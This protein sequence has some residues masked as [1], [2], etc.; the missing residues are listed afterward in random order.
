MFT[1]TRKTLVRL[2]TALILTTT[3]LHSIAQDV[4]T[5]KVSQLSDQQVIQIWQQFAA[6]GVSESDAMKALVKR[7]LKPTDVTAFKKR[8][9]G[10]QSS[11]KS[12]F[13][14]QSIIKDTTD[15]MRDSSWVIEVPDVRRSSSR[16]GYDF[17]ANPFTSFEP[18]LRI[19]TPKNYVLGPDDALNI[20]LTGQ[21]EAEMT[22]KVTPDGNINM[23]Y[24]GLV[25]VN[26]LTIEQAT[27]RIRSKLSQVYPL[28]KSGQTKLSITLDAY[29]T[30]SVFIIGEA[31]R[32]GKYGISSLASL[33]NVLYLSGGPTEN[34]TLRDI[35]LI[36]NNKTIASFDLYEFLQR[37]SFS[38][39]IRLEDQDVISF[40][41]YGKRVQ[42]DGQVKRPAI[43][44]LL[45]KET[46]S[47]ALEYAGGFSDSAYTD[48]LKVMQR[49]G[50]EKVLRDIDAAVFASYIP[51]QADSIY[52]EQINPAFDNSV[53][54]TGAVYRPGRYGFQET[55]TLRKLIEKADGLRTDAFLNRGYIKRL[56]ATREREM[57]AFDLAASSVD[58]SADIKIKQ[59]DS[60]HI[61]TRDELT[62]QQ[63]I[64]IEGFVRNPGKY[65]FRSGIQLQDL[66]VMAGGFSADAAFHRVEVSRLDKNRSDTLAN[67]LLSVNKIE[68]D[69]SLSG[70]NGRYLLEPQDY[71]FVPR[72][73]NY[74]S[75]GEVKVGGEV[76]FPGHFALERRDE[77]IGDVISRAGGLNQFGA[78]ENAQVFRNGV[79][80]GINLANAS[81][82]SA[83]FRLLPND[84]LFIPRN[85]P[86]VEVAGAVYNPQ[87]LKHQ[88]NRFRYYI[89]AAGGVKQNGALGRSYVQYGN[90]INRRTGKFLFI[91]FYP[92]VKP[93]SKIIVPE[94]DKSNRG[95]S[96]GELTAVSGILSALVG[97]LAI[98]KL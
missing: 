24:A 49:M 54:I 85:D 64:T 10:L 91:R 13:N 93:G 77:T 42:L 26:G 82:G 38:Q 60:I 86:F 9:V 8:L 57:I 43:Y 36:R 62:P 81:S 59:G 47:K 22:A 11:T 35:R 70:T 27:A 41:V 6:N 69:S 78:I 48:R 56:S 39:D 4:S 58:F 12:K 29:R 5:L 95:L 45:E 71:I 88:S 98:L 31:E 34:G 76:L 2:L 37:G 72:L 89:S 14:T 80:V 83:N 92:A 53:T 90:G 51:S 30:I 25:S 79:R 73:L 67:T 61:P 1:M 3:A 18:N 84:S 17:F 55:L 74:R 16:Y 23:Q 40:P 97:L 19:A 33:F 52:A 46:L 7:G 44:E 68:L 75:L 20:T 15:F 87:L 21:N 65:P 32:P 66:I 96:T 94:Q 50:K 63:Y 28:L